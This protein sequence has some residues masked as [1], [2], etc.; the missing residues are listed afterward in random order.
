MQCRVTRPA[1]ARPDQR[2]HL[3]VVKGGPHAIPW[4][5]ADQV[6]AA[7]LSFLRS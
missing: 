3:A 4:T 5:H 6:N 2:H 1:A 7:L